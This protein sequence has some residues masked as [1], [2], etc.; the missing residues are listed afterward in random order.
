MSE[1][2]DLR[3]LLQET[4][5]GREILN[6]KQLNPELRNKLTSILINHELNKSETISTQKFIELAR[7]IKQV[8]PEENIATYYTP[9]TKMNNIIRRL[10]RGKLIDKYHN[11]RKRFKKVGL[12]PSNLDKSTE[13]NLQNQAATKEEDVELVEE[14][15][16]WLKNNNNA[17]PLVIE[18]WAATTFR[19]MNLY[20]N[21]NWTIT[22]YLNTY[23]AL[24]Q[25]L[26]YGLYEIDFQ[27][28]YPEKCNMLYGTISKLK[29]KIFTFAESSKK[30]DANLLQYMKMYKEA[31]NEDCEN[32]I[33]FLIVS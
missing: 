33:C 9:F 19:R 31:L 23:R 6:S 18:N 14:Q 32:A 27:N 28:L 20:N 26:G 11:L 10:A 2:F 8:F 15:L 1:K 16:I 3:A 17:W 12:F 7:H 30:H 13:E 25:P 29:Q 4:L 22:E 21:N 24:K 5:A